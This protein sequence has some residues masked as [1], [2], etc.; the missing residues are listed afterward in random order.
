MAGHAKVFCC[1]DHNKDLSQGWMS[2]DH[3]SL[4]SYLAMVTIRL[5]HAW[6][7]T[8]CWDLL[9]LLQFCLH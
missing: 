2:R 5:H 3:Y 8:V 1:N 7:G 4:A 9:Q 6:A